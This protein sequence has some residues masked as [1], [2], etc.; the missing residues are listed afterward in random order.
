MRNMI[1]NGKMQVEDRSQV[2]KEIVINIIGG[3]AGYVVLALVAW[4]VILL[5]KKKG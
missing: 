1:I 2:R 3:S 4:I 5:S